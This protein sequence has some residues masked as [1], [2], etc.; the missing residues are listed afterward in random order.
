[1]SKVSLK[2]DDDK[3]PLDLLSPYF[4]DAIAQVLAFGAKKY[5][6]WNW[7]KTGF[8]TSR[9]EAAIRRHINA[10]KC[11]EELD[12]ESGLPHL[13]HAGCMLMFLIHQECLPEKY[14]HLRDTPNFQTGE[15][16]DA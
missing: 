11:G 12:S 7:I 4:E 14:Q 1:M 15:W 8:K 5:S 6:R 13:W 9:L 16:S 2:F 3:V 10:W